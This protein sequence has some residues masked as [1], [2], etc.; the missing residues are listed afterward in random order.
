M[1]RIPTTPTSPQHPTS[2][3][4]TQP[5][6]TTPLPRPIQPNTN[7]PT[8]ADRGGTIKLILTATHSTQDHV[9]PSHWPRRS[10]QSYQAYSH[11]SLADRNNPSNCH[12]TGQH[13][14]PTSEEISSPVFWVPDRRILQQD[15]GREHASVPKCCLRF[16]VFFVIL[17]RSHVSHFVSAFAE[18]V[19]RAKRAECGNKGCE[20]GGLGWGAMEE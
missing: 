10:D 3:Q 16:V 7:R 20:L 8:P 4:P 1:L 6:S 19:G 17:L 13:E 2:P 9:N 12:P 18:L 5:T 11:I 15:R 14:L